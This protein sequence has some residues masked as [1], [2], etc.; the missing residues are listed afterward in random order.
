MSYEPTVWK[1]GD[2]VTSAKLN[3]MEQGI[4]AGGSSVF[5]VNAEYN[6]E[7]DKTVLNKT[8]EEI[9]E[10]FYH[11]I[12]LIVFDEFSTLVLKIENAN[13]GYF[14]STSGPEFYTNTLNDYPIQAEKEII[15]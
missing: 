3:K 15:L 12:V 4:A 6:E 9:I 8:A 14:F 2:L 5:I 11:G 13:S 1:D 10:A 7:T